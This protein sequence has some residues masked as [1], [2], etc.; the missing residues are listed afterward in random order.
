MGRPSA[1]ASSHSGREVHS[2]NSGC[3]RNSGTLSRM[4]RTPRVL[5]QHSVAVARPAAAAASHSVSARMGASVGS[6]SWQTTRPVVRSSTSLPRMPWRA[7]DAPVTSVVW[8]GHV[9]LGNAGRSPAAATPRAASAR[10]VGIFTAA[11]PNSA[12]EKPSMLISRTAGFI[13]TPPGSA[14]ASAR[15][16]PGRRR[17]ARRA[18]SSPR[19]AR[20]RSPDRR[21]APA[22]GA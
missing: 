2:S 7:G 5:G 6:P 18:P 13:V 14:A 16:W 8:Q 17:A 4:L 9:T 10:S 1:R 11:S 22:P 15:R 12:A 3:S 20:S 21:R 19:P